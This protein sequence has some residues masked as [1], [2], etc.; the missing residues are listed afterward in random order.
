MNDMSSVE[1]RDTL[2]FCP[3]FDGPIEQELAFGFLG[4]TNRIYVF[5]R[6]SIFKKI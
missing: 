2:S 6:K 3:F 4:Q 5:G 1:P